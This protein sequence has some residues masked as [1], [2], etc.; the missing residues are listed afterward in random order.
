M[1]EEGVMRHGR[2]L[3]G[4][5]GWCLPEKG[6]EILRQEKALED[7]IIR[8]RRLA[9]KSGLELEFEMSSEDILLIREEDVPLPDDLLEVLQMSQMELVGLFETATKLLAEADLGEGMRAYV[10]RD[11]SELWQVNLLSA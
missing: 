9:I 1:E 3:N 2:A 5:L 4:D 7:R 8:Q 10:K 11:S 6:R